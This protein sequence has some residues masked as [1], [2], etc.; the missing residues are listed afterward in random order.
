VH[1]AHLCPIS[2]SFLSCDHD[3]YFFNEIR[4]Y[5]LRRDTHDIIFIPIAPLRFSVRLHSIK[6]LVRVVPYTYLRPSY[7]RRG[8]KLYI[9]LPIEPFPR[10]LQQKCNVL[11]HITIIIIIITDRKGFDFDIF[12]L[13]FASRVIILLYC[14]VEKKI[15]CPISYKCTLGTRIKRPST[16]IIGTTRLVGRRVG[17]DTCV[18]CTD[19]KWNGTIET[20]VVVPATTE[21]WL[22]RATKMCVRVYILQLAGRKT[23]IEND[24]VS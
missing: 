24:F 14:T 2:Y 23:T 3:W 13:F 11:S 16:Y 22:A 20:V 5:R 1:V 10:F 6:T 15:V 9:G 8:L 4:V 17:R 21:G 18:W 7:M 19:A 12:K